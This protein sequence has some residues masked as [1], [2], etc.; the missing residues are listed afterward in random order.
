MI[1]AKILS[2]LSKK[3]PWPGKSV[4]ASLIPDLRFKNDSK[5]SPIKERRLIVK[6]NHIIK[7]EKDLFKNINIRFKVT[8]L[9]MQPPIKPS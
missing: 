2:N 7:L 4:P 9:K 6:E 8:K 1:A 5:R 3:P